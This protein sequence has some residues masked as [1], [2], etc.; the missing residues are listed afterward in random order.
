MD[1]LPRKMCIYFLS[2]FHSRTV[3]NNQN[4]DIE[5]IKNMSEKNSMNVNVLVTVG[6]IKLQFNGSAEVVMTSVITFL[7]KQL[8]AIDSARKISLNY[9]VTKR[10]SR[11]IQI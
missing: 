5:D 3:N 2:T 8:P 1:S 11:D 7:A 10:L 4:I 6:D 9:A